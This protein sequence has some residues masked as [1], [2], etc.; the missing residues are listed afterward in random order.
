MKKINYKSAHYLRYVAVIALFFTGIMAVNVSMVSAQGAQRAIRIPGNTVSNMNLGAAISDSIA[1]S[2]FTIEMWVK[3]RIHWNNV[4]ELQVLLGNKDIDEENSPGIYW[5]WRPSGG[6]YNLRFHFRPEG[7]TRINYSVPFVNPQEWNHLAMTIDRNGFAVCYINGLQT[8]IYY[9]ISQDAGK[10]I[11]AGLPLRL[12]SD[13]TGIYGDST[14]MDIDEVR[15]W[16]TSRSKEQLRAN[17][18]HKLSGNEAGLLAYYRMDETTGSIIDNS[19]TNYVTQFTGT[20]ENNPERILSGAALGDESV[21]MYADT[22]NVPTV[23][24]NFPDVWD[25]A[26]LSIAA[27]GQGSLIV[28][29]ISDDTWGMQVYRINGSPN[30]TQSIHDIGTTSQYFGVFPVVDVLYATGNNAGFKAKYDYTNYPNAVANA[31]SLHLYHRQDNSA[32]PWI[33]SDALN[34][35]IT[36]N[37]SSYHTWNV[38]EFIL[39]DFITPSCPVPVNLTATDIDTNSAVLRWQST[40]PAHI[41]EYGL[42]QYV[43]GTGNSVVSFSDSLFLDNLSLATSY[44]F[45]MK[46]SCGVNNTSAWVGPFNFN[47]LTVCPEPY[48]IIADSITRTSMVLK[49]EDDGVAT[50]G[51][52]VVWGPQGFGNITLGI[53]QDVTEK[54][55]ALNNLFVNFSYDF[56]IRAQCPN[57]SILNSDWVGPFT[58]RTLSCNKAT[59]ISTN[60]ITSTTAEATWVSDATSWNIEYGQAGFELGSGYSLSRLPEPK[61]SFAGLTPDREYAYYLQESCNAGTNPWSGPYTFHTSVATTSIVSTSDNDAKVLIYPN[62]VKGVLKI[63]LLSDDKKLQ[64]IYIKNSLGLPVLSVNVQGKTEAV[65]DVSSLKNAMYFIEVWGD[66]FKCQQKILKLD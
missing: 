12:G 21:Y 41:I 37:L 40:A 36:Y 34:N 32:S 13:G 3:M 23:W 9:D 64:Q 42:H 16:K 51:Y 59:N 46:D 17:M 39:A 55:F 7:G 47:T 29:S 53:E 25:T 28:D 45:Y 35:T 33:Q 49:W 11:T 31:A 58:Y 44:D 62:P 63:S 22:S 1:T 52:T 2:N 57:A 66:D 10:S 43:P 14:D 48:S 50:E 15:I 65:I 27:P 60:N 56:Y 26:S 20:L 38:E 54:R 6:W 8:G 30:D 19:A 18:C 24:N 61:Y 4:N 5:T